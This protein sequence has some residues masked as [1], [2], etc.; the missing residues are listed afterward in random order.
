MDITGHSSD[1][2]VDMTFPVAVRQFVARRR[3][4]W[5][6]LFLRGEPVGA[7]SADWE[8]PAADAG[9]DYPDIIT[10]SSGQE[11]EDF[12]GANGY[13]LDGT[14]EG[15]FSVFY[16]LHAQPLRAGQVTGVRCTAPETATALEGAGLLLGA[17]F[18]V[19]LVTP[20]DP[21]TDPFSGRVLADFLE[22]F[23]SPSP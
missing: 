19:S 6:G 2:I 23:G 22:S 1:F 11:M 13:A 17:Y 9:D 10:F 14:G 7:S 4:Q 3:Q 18:S 20:E 15:P 5:P 16:R 12:W 21:A 8:L